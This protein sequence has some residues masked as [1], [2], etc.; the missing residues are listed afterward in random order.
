MNWEEWKVFLGELVGLSASGR[1]VYLLVPASGPEL[2]EERGKDLAQA[3]H[4]FLFSGYSSAESK[5]RLLATKPA[6][7]SL[8]ILYLSR[9]IAYQQEDV[10]AF[11]PPFRNTVIRNKLS[12]Q[13]VQQ[14]LA[15]LL[16]ALWMKCHRESGIYRPQEG[17]VH[18]KWPQAHAG[19]TGGE[20]ELIT[21]LVVAA[22]TVI[23]EEPPDEL[24]A[25]PYEFLGLLRSW[26][27]P[28]YHVSKRL[29]RL[30]FGPDGPALLVA[31][32]AQNLLID[33]WPPDKTSDIT[34][35]TGKTLSPYVRLGLDPLRF[36]VVLPA[37]SLP[38][39][40][41]LDAYYSDNRVQ[42]ETSH[43]EH[44]TSYKPYEWPIIQ[45]PWVSEVV[46]KSSD[47][48]IKMKVTP[49]CPIRRNR[50]DLMMFDASTGRS[51]RQWYPN[52]HY[53]L[54][55]SQQE[56][57]NWLWSL[58]E[59][60]DL[61]DS[62]RI[63]DIEMMALSAVGRDIGEELD[64]ESILDF[65]E[66][67]EGQID[68]AGAQITL[69]DYDKLVQ[70]DMRFVGGLPV[71][72]SQYPTYI[73][74]HEPLV[75][76]W[77][78]KGNEFDISIYQRQDDGREILYDS[79]KLGSNLA[80]PI[81][82]S[83]PSLEA[84][85]YVIRGLNAPKYLNL[86]PEVNY[87]PINNMHVSLRLLHD[88]KVISLDDM[89]HFQSK[90]A[91]ITSW[92]FSR[93]DLK[94]QTETGTH[95]FPIRTDGEGKRIVLANE[96]N[97]PSTTKWVKLQGRAWLAQSETVEL[98]LRPYVAPNDW[99]ICDGELAAQVKGVQE[100]TPFVLSFVPDRPWNSNIEE[101]SG[102]VDSN[103]ELRVNL[104]SENPIRW[105]TLSDASKEA[106]WLLTTIGQEDT[107]YTNEDFFLAYKAGCR[108]PSHISSCIPIDQ[109]F[110]EMRCIIWVAELA[111]YANI[112]LRDEPLPENINKF[113][114]GIDLRKF[115]KIRLPSELDNKEARVELQ[116]YSSGDGILSVDKQAFHVRLTTV[117]SY[118]KMTWLESS[119]PCICLCC[120]RLM[121]Q[122][123]W[124]SH[125]CSA[126]NA[127][128]LGK[129]EFVV[130][131]IVD[132]L[133]AMGTIES[134]LLE[135]IAEGAK[136]GPIELGNVW[137]SLQESFRNREVEG[138]IS[139]EA[140]VKNVFSI[141]RELFELVNRSSSSQN[142]TAMWESIATYRH[143]LVNL[144]RG[145][146]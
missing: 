53:I 75:A 15:P 52:R 25:E 124:L 102:V 30:I 109:R 68:K 18:V 38:G 127:R 113:L 70:P 140:W 138:V 19:L 146:S 125:E 22:N 63:G 11:W 110:Q 123:R 59:N 118:L 88:E 130:E 31:E 133:S 67:M 80:D 78:T 126:K 93:V 106:V 5:L 87:P 6:L 94:V 41:M 79:I 82:F 131:P 42:L 34:F 57:P 29:S 84:G 136:D 44:L 1:K 119:G 144:V 137:T 114:K 96:I 145:G 32:L 54:L 95:S 64:R 100:G 9:W 48:I 21:N 49:E 98:V 103:L 17:R 139:P 28:Q 132:W 77:H 141:W 107:R 13:T 121:T 24:Y 43:S 26:L 20:K 4:Q 3:V 129:R 128:V 122:A 62:G 105:I 85:F 91:Q 92:P 14:R 117:G 120:Q 143:A 108:L 50:F 60:I 61:V 83:L 104:P 97:L 112:P 58:F 81:V 35:V 69:P 116:N 12:D 72:E 40:T 71:T 33:E 56:L 99:S 45:L 142:W 74:G 36:S 89:R 101:C 10:H 111:R 134:A 37:G 86:V 65:I 55:G 73:V 8:P 76:I 7:E 23:T 27:Q 39:Y 66:E 16:T 90:G 2:S 51:M 47:S 135:A 115:L 46:L